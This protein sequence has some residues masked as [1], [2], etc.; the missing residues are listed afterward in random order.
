M[1]LILFLILAGA[2]QSD[3]RRADLDERAFRTLLDRLARAWNEGD[4]RAAAD[5]FTADAVY[6]EPPDRQLYR[7]RE[8]LYLFFGGDAGRPGAMS[9]V[10]HNVAFDEVRQIGLGEFTF[11][12]GSQVHG[13]VVL[14]VREGRIHRWREYWYE[15]PLDFTTFA[16][17]S[18]FE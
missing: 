5:C 12:Y 6:A 10:W 15:S 16:G 1:R 17:E 14:Q 11:S 9:M 7:G 8:E 2:C 4:A 3:G 13:A 18:A